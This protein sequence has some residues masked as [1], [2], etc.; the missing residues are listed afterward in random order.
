MTEP[1]HARTAKHGSGRGTPP[2]RERWPIVIAIVAVLT[3][4]SL[5]VLFVQ[6]GPRALANLQSALGPHWTSTAVPQ[7]SPAGVAE[8]AKPIG[9]YDYPI[10]KNA[11]YVSP[12][13]KDSNDGSRAHPFFTVQD[14]ISAADPG[15]TIILRG[16]TYNQRVTVLPG[17]P[18]TIEP[19]PHEKVWFDGS[20]VVSHWRSSNGI[21]VSD[22]W[23]AQFDDSPTFT[24]GAAPSTRPDFAFINPSYPLASH[25]DQVWID[26]KALTQVADQS[27][28]TAGTFAVDYATS[29]LFIGTDPSGHVV[30]ASNKSKAFALQASGTVLRGIGVRDYATSLPQFGAISLEAPRITVEDL[31][32][33]GDA[34]TGLF[35]GAADCVVR[36]VTSTDNGMIGLYANFADRLK[37]TGVISDHNNLQHFNQAPVAGGFKITSSRTISIVDSRFDDNLGS[38][39]WF[40]ESDYNATVA[41][42]TMSDNSGHGLTM[43]IS[44]KFVVAG[45]V[46][47]NNRGNGINLNDTDDVQ[48]WHNTVANNAIDFRAVQDN[49]RASDPSIPGHN[50]HRPANDPTMPWVV[51]AVTASDNVFSGSTTGELV[52]VQD[53]SGQ[54]TAAGLDV[55]LNGNAYQRATATTP[56]TL[57]LWG[58]RGNNVATGFD[59]LRAFRRATGQESS[60]V[61]LPFASA[62]SRSWLGSSATDSSVGAT[63]PPVPAAILALLGWTSSAEPLGAPS[64]GS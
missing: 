25:P 52:A 1:R 40:D 58:Q 50:A 37:V 8:G 6:L 29:Q 46:M 41:R 35:V 7:T 18:V 2:R 61:E 56:A 13:G 23:S 20:T 21:W 54:Y 47:V 16:G 17:N 14:A 49:R 60:G 4:G 38:G 31:D 5:V 33:T 26:G 10:P 36:D 3:V 55:T 39:L 62:A 42:D 22:G 53:N 51:S 15:Q 32:V 63:N 48:L 12:R 19:Y 34:T 11:L 24:S 57:V 44:A 27:S 45:D 30:R 9:S 28:V 64:Q 59:T 43:E